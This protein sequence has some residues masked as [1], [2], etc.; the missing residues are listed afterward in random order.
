MTTLSTAVK[1]AQKTDGKGCLILAGMLL[2]PL[3]LCGFILLSLFLLLL[4][5]FGGGEMDRED[6]VGMIEGVKYAKHIN[7]AAEKYGAD[8][9]LIAAI[10]KQESSFDPKAGSHKGAQGLMQVM[11][12]NAKG[13]DLWDPRQNIMR[14]TQIITSHLKTYGGN[15]ELALAAYNAGPGAVKKYGNKVPPY[16]ETQEYVKKVQVYYEEYQVKVVDGK[17]QE[18]PIGKGEL[19]YPA[20]SKV[21]C[22][23]TCYKNHNGVDFSG[24]GD[25]SIFAAGDGKVIEKR[26]LDGRSYGTLVI[27][28]HGGGIQTAYAH[29]EW[30]DIQVE[31]G[32]K[33]KR[34]QKIGKM[35]NNGNS[36]GTHLHFEVRKK[37]KKVNPMPYL[38]KKKK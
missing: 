23:F 7:D 1:V 33:V 9:A 26:D 35:G 32:Q 25:R 34:G 36:T 15:L 18:G 31:A 20:K 16:K 37:G 17:I 29:M 8:P 38:E 24:Q 14:G 5:L 13:K 4:S 21:S 11:P 6:G 30:D 3:F 22:H 10:I 2:L 12:F 19:A 28:D 27:I